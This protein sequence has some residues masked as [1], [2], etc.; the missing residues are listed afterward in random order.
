VA[1]IGVAVLR[2]GAFFGSRSIATQDAFAARSADFIVFAVLVRCAFAVI[3]RFC[4]RLQIAVFGDF[5]NRFSL[6]DILFASLSGQ[7]IVKAY[8]RAVLFFTHLETADIIRVAAVLVR[9]AIYG[10]WAIVPVAISV[11]IATQASVFGN[12]LAGTV[13]VL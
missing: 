10:V 3:F 6:T 5:A 1:V 7:A 8:A 13:R 12:A 11:R 4:I 9:L 2:L